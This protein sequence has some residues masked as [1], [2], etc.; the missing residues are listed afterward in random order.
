P[1]WGIRIVQRVGFLPCFKRRAEHG[2]K[3]ALKELRKFELSTRFS[4]YPFDNGGCVVDT[5]LA[6]TSLQPL[7]FHAQLGGLLVEF[8]L[9]AI[10][11]CRLIAAPCR[12]DCNQ[13]QHDSF[14]DLQ[15]LHGAAG[16]RRGVPFVLVQFVSN[17]D[18]WPTYLVHTVPCS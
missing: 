4:L 7:C 5:L 12:G 9:A 8:I 11:E 13:G 6:T 18:A 10:P 15:D 16:M 14:N 3:P 17:F 1:G 2:T